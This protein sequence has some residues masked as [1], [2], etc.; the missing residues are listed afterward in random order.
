[1]NEQ[2][3]R[4]TKIQDQID[5]LNQI[6][7]GALFQLNETSGDF[8][9]GE[10]A[11]HLTSTVKSLEENIDQLPELTGEFSEDVLNEKIKNYDRQN[12]QEASQLHKT[13][14]QTNSWLQ[15]LRQTMESLQ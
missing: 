5:E 8:E 10:F 15:Q 12:Q 14:E 2:D 7:H 3:D 9:V 6:F 11:R 13:L 4:L 1:M